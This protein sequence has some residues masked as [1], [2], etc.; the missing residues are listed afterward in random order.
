VLYACKGAHTLFTR[1]TE[2][3]REREWKGE[4]ESTDIYSLSVER[5]WKGERERESEKEGVR[6]RVSESIYF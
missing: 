2:R 4:R 1:Q 5:E 6:E 3:E